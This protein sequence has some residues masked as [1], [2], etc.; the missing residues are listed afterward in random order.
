MEV[1]W[2][3]LFLLLRPGFL[4]LWYWFAT[5]GLAGA[6]FWEF[7]SRH[8][9]VDTGPQYSR[10]QLKAT[11]A[12]HAS[13][14]TN[15]RKKRNNQ[16]FFWWGFPKRRSWWDDQHDEKGIITDEGEDDEDE[17]GKNWPSRGGYWAEHCPASQHIFTM[18]STTNFNLYKR[19]LHATSPEWNR[20]PKI[21]KK[22]SRSYN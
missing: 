6:T 5:F 18:N 14:E 13:E 17:Q 2:K 3:S 22:T 20:S 8:V 21:V 1:N 4:Y 19:T 10:F 9:T 7:L 16:V 12:M 15:K 11:Q